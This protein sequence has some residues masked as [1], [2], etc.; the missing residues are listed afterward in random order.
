MAA[1][2]VYRLDDEAL[3]NQYMWLSRVTETS[4][5]YVFDRQGQLVGRAP[6]AHAGPPL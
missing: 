1:L 2:V 5:S 4:E 6:F 3:L